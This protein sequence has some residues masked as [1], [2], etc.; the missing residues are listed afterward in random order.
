MFIL[1]AI[2]GLSFFN[3][4]IFGWVSNVGMHINN[5]IRRIEL[6][7]QSSIVRKNLILPNSGDSDRKS[8]V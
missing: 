7:G 8:V 1:V 5:D 2:V 6:I 4:M 3:G